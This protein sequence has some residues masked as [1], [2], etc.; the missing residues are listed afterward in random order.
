MRPYL[1]AAFIV[2][3]SLGLAACQ[4]PD[5]GQE[6]ALD[7]QAT[8]GGGGGQPTNGDYLETGNPEC[9]GLVCVFSAH[10][11][12]AKGGKAGINPY[13]SKPCVADR[14]CFTGQTGLV[15]RG[16]VLDQDFLNTLPDD[17]RKKYLGD[18]NASNYCAV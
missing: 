7:F 15:C 12:G 8:D 6:C 17:I 2:L 14:D 11:T 13:C 1:V 10:S 16:V 5:V 18:I 4:D 3:G 9:A